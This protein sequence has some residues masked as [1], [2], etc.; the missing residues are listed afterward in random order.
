MDPLRDRKS[1]AI[2]NAI[3]ANNF[4]QALKL[5]DKKLA[6]KHDDYLEVR[7]RQCVLVVVAARLQ[8]RRAYT[9]DHEEPLVQTFLTTFPGSQDIH[10]CQVSSNLREIRCFDSSRRTS[11]SETTC[12]GPGCD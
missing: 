2:W 12:L 3:E 9:R 6:K 7:R 10:P 5:V 11:W 8:N 4:K 1:D